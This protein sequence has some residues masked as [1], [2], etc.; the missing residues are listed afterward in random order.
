MCSEI[1]TH[2]F[3]DG[4][5]VAIILLDTQGIFDNESTMKENTM[6]FSI[7]MMIASVQCYNVM[8]RVQENDLQNLHFFSEY[9]E[10]V[11]REGQFHGTPFQKLPFFLINLF[12]K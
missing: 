4:E 3:K 10:L 5:K 1:F 12:D 11:M 2:D 6:T 9:G 7:S 8:Q